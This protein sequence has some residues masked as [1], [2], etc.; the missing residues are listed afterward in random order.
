APRGSPGPRRRP[1]DRALARRHAPG[2]GGAPRRAR[3]ARR[4]GRDRRAERLV[5]P[6]ARAARPPD[7]RDARHLTRLVAAAG[8]VEIEIEA[9]LLGRHQVWLLIRT[10]P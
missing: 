1:P 3:A 7:H 10:A 5:A 6:I 9:S 4:R 2:G 8:A